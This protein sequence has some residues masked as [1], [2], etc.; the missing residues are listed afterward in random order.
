MSFSTMAFL[1][2]NVVFQQNDL[3]CQSKHIRRSQFSDW[4]ILYTDTAAELALSILTWRLSLTMRSL[5]TWKHDFLTCLRQNGCRSEVTF[6]VS[7]LQPE[8][9]LLTQVTTLQP[10]TYGAP[11]SV[12]TCVSI[13]ERRCW[14][15]V[16]GVTLLLLPVTGNP[17]NY[18]FNSYYAVLSNLW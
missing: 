14:A 6:R 18:Y 3:V 8:R 10:S 15:V 17:T 13:C 5:K 4:L 9:G 11:W 1:F 7:S 16:L 2:H 12:V